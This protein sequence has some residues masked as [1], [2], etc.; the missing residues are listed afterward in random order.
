[1]GSPEQADQVVA[2]FTAIASRR[3]IEMVRPRRKAPIASPFAPILVREIEI[4]LDAR[5]AV[6]ACGGLEFPD[7]SPALSN[8]ETTV[9]I[10]KALL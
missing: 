4:K 10:F 8:A 5:R 1:M 7:T 3:R 9:L 6:E 2:F